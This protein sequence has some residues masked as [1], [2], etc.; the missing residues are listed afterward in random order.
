MHL[1]PS[2]V[3]TH[4]TQRARAQAHVCDMGGA[5]DVRS[6]GLRVSRSRVRARVCARAKCIS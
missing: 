2:A 4:L 3:Q 1:L 6:N 5:R